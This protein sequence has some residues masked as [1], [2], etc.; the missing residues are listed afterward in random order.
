[1][2]NIIEF[3]RQSALDLEQF[4]G[5]DIRSVFFV[6]VGA[7]VCSLIIFAVYKYFYKGVIYNENFNILLVL[8]TLIAAFIVMVFARNVIIALGMVGALGMIRIIRFRTTIKDPLDVGFILWSLAAGIVSGIGF[9]RVAILV[10]IGIGIVY[11]L[12]SKFI[13]LN[14]VYLLVVNYEQNEKKIL[15]KLENIKYKVKTKSESKK[16][17]ELVVQFSTKKLKLD[18]TT[19]ISAVEGV[20]NVSLVE[21]DGDFTQ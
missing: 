13:R 17:K 21:Y 8:V 5:M 15:D 9:S 7:L 1:M 20:N 12:L 10:S 19:E 2:Q 3:F 6:M 18:L 4:I 14:S 11:I 16:G